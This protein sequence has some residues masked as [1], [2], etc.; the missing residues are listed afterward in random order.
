MI[1]KVEGIR[2]TLEVPVTNQ[3]ASA[4]RAA[5]F[6]VRVRAN[7]ITTPYEKVATVNAPERDAIYFARGALSSPPKCDTTRSPLFQKMNERHNALNNAEPD[8]RL[9]VVLRSKLWAGSEVEEGFVPSGERVFY[10][11][12]PSGARM[13]LL[14][15]AA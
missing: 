11:K 13:R 5:G 10:L 8:E 1:A 14:G 4:L 7:V 3:E 2:R 15:S 12:H 9:A 6:E